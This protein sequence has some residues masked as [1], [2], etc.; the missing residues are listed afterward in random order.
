MTVSLGALLA[1]ESLEAASTTSNDNHDEAPDSKPPELHPKKPKSTEELL[2]EIL[3]E[4]RILRQRQ[5]KNKMINWILIGLVALVLIISLAVCLQAMNKMSF[6][7]QLM[8]AQMKSGN[9]IAP[10]FR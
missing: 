6:M 1:Q 5:D 2:Q 3:H 9:S 10:S 7:S 4:M 8:L